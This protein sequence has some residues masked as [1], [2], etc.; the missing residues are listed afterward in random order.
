MAA[1]PT[2]FFS[3]ERRLAGEFSQGFR[4]EVLKASLSPRT[5]PRRAPTCAVG[6]PT[7]PQNRRRRSAII[8]A[9]IP[10]PHTAPSRL[11][12]ILPHVQRNKPPQRGV[13][14][15]QHQI[16]THVV[17]RRADLHP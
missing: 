13:R 16:T 9:P 10:D 2:A 15:M 4:K 5:A 3:T 14:F 17:L 12:H 7:S 1:P 6:A 11:K 8:G